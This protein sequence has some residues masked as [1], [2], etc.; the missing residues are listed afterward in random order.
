ML[1]HVSQK[2]KAGYTHEDQKKVWE[3]WSRFEPPPGIEIKMNVT[4]VD[5]RGF[6]FIE[7]E[8]AEVVFE[9]AAVWAGAYV[10]YEIVPVIE[11]DKALPLM[12]KAFA[13]REG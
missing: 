10:D 4:A 13:F 9:V 2:Y 6:A 11:V 12:E 8:S 5:G 1:F 7:A 3:S